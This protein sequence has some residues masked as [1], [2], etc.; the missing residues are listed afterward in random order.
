MTQ[1]LNILVLEDNPTDA[2]LTLF[3]LEEAGFIISAKVVATEKEYVRE[4]SGCPYDL[5][6]SDYD[7]PRYN[8]SLALLEAVK[9]CPGTPFILVTGA[10]SEDRAIEIL[11][12]GAKDYVLKNRLQQRLVPAVRR[13]LAE[14]EELKARKQAEEDLREAHKNLERQVGERTAELQRELEQRRRIEATLLKY[15]ERLEIL[16]FTA[17]RLLASDQPQQIV[18]ELCLKV[19][20]FLDCQ[21]FFNFLVDE[22]AGRL[23]L[24]ACAG[25]PAETAREIEWLDYGVAVCGC[26]ARDACR[27]VAEDIPSTPDVRTEL[28]KSFGIKAYACH[29]LLAQNHVIGTLSFGTRTRTAFNADDL[30]M[31]KAVADQVAVAMNRVRME[32]A[33]RASESREKARAG[34]MQALMDA[35][36]IA[37]WIAHD[38]QCRRITG[39]R[40]ADEITRVPHDV[41]VSVTANPGDAAVTYQVFRNGI[42]IKPEE[43]PAQI[44]ASTGRPVEAEMLD[45][46]FSDGRVVRLIEGAMPLFDAE[47]C[48]RGSVAAGADVTRLRTV[49]EELRRTTERFEMAQHAA[50]VGIWDWDVIT[51]DIRWSAQMFYL[52]GLD[53]QRNTASFELWKSILHPEDIAIAENRINEALLRKTALNGDYRIT[54]PDGQI[55]WINAVGEGQ[56]D[57]QDRP[58]RM[59]G[60]CM[61]VTERK[62]AEEALRLSEEKYRSLVK[63]AP[64][65]IYEVNLE[66]TK[67]LGMNDVMC[68]LLGYSREE[69]L[70][71]APSE[72]LSEESSIPFQERTKRVLAGEL[73]AETA[74]YRIRKKDG[75]WI[76]A[77][78]N[79]GLFAYTHEKPA[80]IVVIAH[81]IT[82]RKKMEEALRESEQ[83]LKF[84]FE[85][86]P[87]AV[88]E[89]D[90]DFIVTQ[91]SGEAERLFGWKK[92]EV[93][94]KRIDA[95]HLIYE[96]DI[97]VLNRTMEKLTSGET[98]AVVS[99]N[100]N[101]TKTGAVIESRWHNSVIFNAKGE[102]ESVMSLVE[103]IT[104][105]KRTEDAILL[106]K[107]EW[108]RTFDT[109]PDLITILDTEHRIVR[110]NKA[111]ADRL[112][113]APP[114]CI[115]LHCHE[116][117]HGMCEPPAFCPHSLTCED[118]RQ[119]VAEVHEPHLGGDFLVSTTPLHGHDGRLVGSVHVARD[120]TARKQAEDLLARQAAELQERTAQLEVANQELESFSYSVSHDLRAPLRAIDGLSRIILRQQDQLD[121][122]SRRQFNMIRDNIKMMGVLI[123]NLLSFSRVQK[124][125]MK[126]SVIDMD[127]L[128]REV[129]DELRDANMERELEFKMTGILPGCGDQNLIRQVLL[130]LL[131]NAVKFTK[132]RKPGII[133]MSSFKETGK[134]VYCVKDNGA[135]F[136]M[137]YASKLFGVFQRLHSVEEYEGTGVGLAIVQR[138]IN[139]HGGRVWGEGKENGGAAFYFALPQ[140]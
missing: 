85:K 21:A 55:R 86:S 60:I 45:L 41:N 10:V 32:D 109:V 48:V 76:Y 26:A 92:E 65:A 139:R 100:R 118:G 121:E 43:L 97:P 111:M 7:L 8:G 35:A 134:I 5:I 120:I 71:M 69:L 129:W 39:N 17:G 12:Q 101:Y 104:E 89:W 28:V 9:R 23:H 119:H 58:V 136:D 117:V 138:I 53:P 61:D 51:G 94:G 130:N 6:L 18:K 81:D 3:E 15:N 114:C 13:A 96:D 108:E 88:V 132:N 19:M 37:I 64:A 54:L 140:K 50:E 67:F 80:R 113:V 125:S 29:P 59:M 33:L 128:A 135:G 126:T 34:E 62:Q 91:W 72:L 115:G 27:I 98:H 73:I 95:L 84:H 82:E 112:G 106:A 77:I 87:L 122:T 68:D 11:T 107:E 44:A 93:I 2:E 99:T 90:T 56:Y 83:R 4:L 123:D 78:V 110:V 116:A 75:T 22:S 103:D 38:P 25:I 36:P 31:M 16:S 20:T 52:F 124:T 102:M 127:K 70:S 133:E 63:Y 57:N 42:E 40:Y 24:N 1:S 66:G 46:I 131:D 49:E 105:R 30:A 137:E 74:E 47:G 14:A 79:A